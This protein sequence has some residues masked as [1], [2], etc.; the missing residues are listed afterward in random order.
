M[1]NGHDH[2]IDIAPGDEHLEGGIGER[3]LGYLAGLGLAILLTA[4][5]FFVAGTD[6]RLSLFE[7]AERAKELKQRGEM[8]ELLDTTG[9]AEVPQTFPNGCHVAE[10]EIDSETGMVTL[11]A[12]T[13][14]DDCGT[15]LDP[16]L[17]EGQVQGGVAQGP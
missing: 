12:Y 14:V 11:A 17:V 15:M 6:R 7:V 10:V 16:V 8:A 1:T 4:T 13:A 9:R 5:S 2:N 3:V